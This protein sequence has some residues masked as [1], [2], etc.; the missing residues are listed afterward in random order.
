MLA[1]FQDLDLAFLVDALWF[2]SIIS[3]CGL[4]NEIEKRL[5]IQ[6]LKA[7][8]VSFFYLL[9]LIGYMVHHDE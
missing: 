6:Y 1:F 3:I 2:G 7:S 8:F 5:L 9:L 4:D